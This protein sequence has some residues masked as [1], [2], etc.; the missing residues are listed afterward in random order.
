MPQSRKRPGHHEYKKAADI[1]KSQR[2]KGRVIVAILGA[3]FAT[4]ITYFGAGDNYIYL[5]VAA[6]LGAVIG[7][8]IGKAMEKEA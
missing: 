7:Y 1:P 8:A 2:V 3:V 5:L 4:L 6:V